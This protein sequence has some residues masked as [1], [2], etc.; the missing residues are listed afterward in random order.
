MPSVL[1]LPGAL[2]LRKGL[3]RP[4]LLHPGLL[5]ITMDV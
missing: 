3:L 2:L 5:Q 1:L 4:G